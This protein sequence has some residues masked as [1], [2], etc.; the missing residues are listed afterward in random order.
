MSSH[1]AIVKTRGFEKWLRT[2]RPR[3]LPPELIQGGW[4]W[5]EDSLTIAQPIC[6]TYSYHFSLPTSNPHEAFASLTSLSR[7]HTPPR[8]PRPRTPSVRPTLGQGPFCVRQQA[9]WLAV[10][11]RYYVVQR[12]DCSPLAR[13]PSMRAPG[14]K[15][16]VLEREG[17]MTPGRG[18][19]Q[20]GRVRSV[21][22]ASRQS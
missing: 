15:T 1:L 7:K 16:L 18:R 9:L 14:V 5:V 20:G 8:C 22:P 13:Q 10:K 11:N 6:R 19:S 2:L 12:E 21:S 3:R 17:P 4:T